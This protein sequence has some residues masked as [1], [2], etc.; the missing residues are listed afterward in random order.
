MFIAYWELNN[1][2]TNNFSSIKDKCK[3][4]FTIYL[5]LIEVNFSRNDK[6]FQWL[7]NE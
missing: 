2:K 1:Y 7:K 5:S 6:L 3:L 4:Y